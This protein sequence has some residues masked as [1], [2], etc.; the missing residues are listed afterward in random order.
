MLFQN[1]ML[2]FLIS[3]TQ[4]GNFWRIVKQVFFQVRVTIFSISKKDKKATENNCK[5]NPY[6]SSGQNKGTIWQLQGTE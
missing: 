1:R 4:K 3:E 6:D 5:I 2:L